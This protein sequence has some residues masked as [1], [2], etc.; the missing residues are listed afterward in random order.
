MVNIVLEL[1]NDKNPNIRTLVGAILDYV[2]IHDEHWKQ[3]IKAK[4]F[5]VHN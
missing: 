3:E 5:M 2:Q 4:R 1:L